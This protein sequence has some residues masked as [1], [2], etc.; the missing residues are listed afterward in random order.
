M[1]IRKDC[2][3]TLL[4]TATIFLLKKPKYASV[5]I[6]E[7]TSRLLCFYALGE[8][9]NKNWMNN[10]AIL[11]LSTFVLRLSMR[12]KSIWINPIQDKEWVCNQIWRYC[13]NCLMRRHFVAEQEEIPDGCAELFPFELIEELRSEYLWRGIGIML[14][15][16]EIDHSVSSQI[17]HFPPD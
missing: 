7:D 13:G 4:T 2:D 3:R 11:S 17:D 16:G 10:Q 1:Q 8:R 6:S 15:A 14:A 12:I 9:M 5:N